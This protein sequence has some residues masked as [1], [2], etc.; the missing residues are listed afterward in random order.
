L[1]AADGEPDLP[2]P[3]NTGDRGN[4]MQQDTEEQ[5]LR[6]AM[7]SLVRKAVG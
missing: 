4:L 2:D 6:E 3:G 1:V 7:G 5:M